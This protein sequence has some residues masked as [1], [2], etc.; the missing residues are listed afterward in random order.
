MFQ[1][2]IDDS[3]V[4]RDEKTVYI[5]NDNLHHMKNVVRL[6]AGEVFRVSTTNKNNYR[7]ELVGYDDNRA[8]GKII[9]EED[10]ST[11]LQGEIRLYQGLPK[12]EKMELIIQKAVE[13]GVTEIIPVAMEYSIVKL[14]KEKESKKI[15][16]W[17]EIAKAAA[18]QSKRSIIPKI[19]NVMSLKEAIKHAENNTINLVP[20]ENEEGILG[21]KKIISEIKK[22][23]KV[24]IFVGP[25][26][27]I[28][29]KEIA[30]LKETMKSV[31]LGKRILR[32]ET[33]AIAMCAI[34]M[35]QMEE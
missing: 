11:E 26:G 7:C 6:K 12:Q 25:E 1:F 21:S 35:M 8:L 9:E 23:D 5:T 30:L 22:N 19:E 17:Q 24:G 2:F 10:S 34:V 16:R 13:L 20:Y 14:E 29:D 4:N 32:T 15:L 33:A 28:S 18:K 31:S 3:D 27:G